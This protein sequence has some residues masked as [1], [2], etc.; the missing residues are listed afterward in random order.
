MITVAVKGETLDTRI[1]KVYALTSAKKMG[2]VAKN[3]LIDETIEHGWRRFRT[4]IKQATVD[5]NTEMIFMNDLNN[6]KAIMGYLT[7]G[8][9]DHMVSP[10]DK[11]A[12]HWGGKPGFFSKGHK[13]KGIKATGVWGITDKVKAA[14]NLFII[15]NFEKIFAR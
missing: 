10:R 15:E 5:V 9:P 6:S 2:T 11:K 13:V 14:I 12:L 7:G 8:T 1:K 3:Q 4:N